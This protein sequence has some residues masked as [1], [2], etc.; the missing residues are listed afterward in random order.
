M[1][2][3]LVGAGVSGV[4]LFLP[5]VL[6]GG[7]R[8]V[9]AILAGD[10]TLAALAGFMLLRFVLTMASYGTGAPGGIFA[11][12]LVLGAGL[13]LAAGEIAA[14][15]APAAV[16]HPESFAIVG[17]AAYFTAIVRAPLTA[18]VLMVEMTGNYGLV[19]PLLTASLAAYGVADW[20][21]DRPVYEALLQRDML[22]SQAAPHLD[23]NL[24]LDLTIAAGSPLDGA[25][26]ED[27][28][29]PPGT[30]VILRRRGMHEQVPTPSMRL[31]AGD[32]ITALV[33]AEASAS[34]PELRR[35]AGLL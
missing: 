28:S 31:A 16:E 17:M 15:L 19:L 34:V 27:V 9:D 8:L 11:P 35:L 6:G 23:A 7:D 12:L 33:S 5:G 21:G 24:L 20:L 22:R 4:G 18:V 14:A 2:G 1:T 13:G 30:V 29:L 3:A 26:F 32:A 10:V 25:V